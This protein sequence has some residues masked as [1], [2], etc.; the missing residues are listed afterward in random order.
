MNSQLRVMNWLIVISN[1]SLAG[2]GWIVGVGLGK[3]RHSY[4]APGEGRLE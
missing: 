4:T 2:S 3:L 1:L